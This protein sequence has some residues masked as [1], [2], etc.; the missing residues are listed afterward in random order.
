MVTKGK[1]APEI[2]LKSAELLNLPIEECIGLE[3]SINGVLS[4]CR[5]GMRAVMIPDLQEPTKEV[6]DM[7]YAK[8]NSLTDVIDLLKNEHK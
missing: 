3:D 2:Y 5:A 4:I 7:L 8:L 6:E 1:P